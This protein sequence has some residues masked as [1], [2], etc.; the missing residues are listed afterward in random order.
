LLLANSD[1]IDVN[2][3]DN[4]GRTAYDMACNIDMMI[5]LTYLQC[6]QA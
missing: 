3:R 1:K 4:L 5:L 6:I 2:A